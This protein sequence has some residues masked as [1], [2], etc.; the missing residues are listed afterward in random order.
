MD[1]P[2]LSQ[3]VVPQVTVRSIAPTLLIGFAAVWLLGLGR[4]RKN[5][6]RRRRGS[7]RGRR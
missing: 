7:R 1:L 5:P 6:S 4:W 2:I 3:P